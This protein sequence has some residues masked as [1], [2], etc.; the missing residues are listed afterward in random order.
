VSDQSPAKL[1]SGALAAEQARLARFFQTINKHRKALDL[2]I[3]ESFGDKL[4]PAEWRRAFESAEPHDANRT[5]VVTGDHSTVLNAYVLD[6]D[7]VERL[8]KALPGLIESAR[9]WLRRHD[10]EL[11]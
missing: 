5:M 11:R 4:D 9:V 1:G 10:I 8:R 6:R 7:A 3:Q 2:A